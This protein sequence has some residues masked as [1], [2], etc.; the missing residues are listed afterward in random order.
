MGTCMHLSRTYTAANREPSLECIVKQITGYLMIAMIR[1]MGLL[2]LGVAQSLGRLLGESLWRRR[3][4][5]REVAR[6]NLRLTHPHLTEAQQA[7][8]LHSTLLHN[9]MVATEIG[10]LWGSSQARRLSMVKEVHNEQLLTEALADER[11]LLL[12]A[13]HIGN[14][15]IVNYFLS[16]RCP[17]TVMFKPAKNPVFDGWMRAQREAT[18][19]VLVPT[20]P[21][22]VK[23]L[24]RTLQKGGVAGFLPDQEP[25]QRSGVTVP[26]MNWPTL[27]PRMPF[28][29]L[30]RTKARALMVF[31]V[32]LPNAEGF[33][34]HFLEPDEGIYSSDATESVAALNRSVEAVVATAPEQYQWTYKRFKRQPEGM[35]NPYKEAGVP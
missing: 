17:M 29:L 30:Q 23:A 24:F 10:G 8:M 6:V 35:P 18:G 27:T 19:S 14:W 32:R 13:P 20:T 9:G 3:T 5:S 34:I 28:E 1:F 4:R 7:D 12:L 21:A 25:E 16:E 15:E 26:F 22:G 33:A 2:P 11:G 31:S